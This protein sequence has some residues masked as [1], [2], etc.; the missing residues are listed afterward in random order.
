MGK[1]D[2]LLKKARDNPG[3]LTF[4]EASA[5]AECYGFEL[6]RVK[7]SHHVYKKPGR[8]ELVNLQS[9]SGEAKAYQVRQI[10][11]VIDQDKDADGG[12]DE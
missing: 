12:N 3:G 8:M 11:A 1:C 9:Q 10:L 2:K 7:G 4:T 5:L 6:A